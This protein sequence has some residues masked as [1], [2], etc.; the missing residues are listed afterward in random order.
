MVS[1]Y[2]FV[3]AALAAG[4]V[5]LWAA[6]VV[7][8]RSARRRL[9]VKRCVLSAAALIVS[10]VGYGFWEPCWPEVERVTVRS[11]KLAADEPIRLVQLSDLHSEAEPRLEDSLPGIVAGLRPDLIVFT[12]DAINTTRGL[13]HFRRVMARLAD[14]AP[15]FAVRGNWDV[16]WFPRTNLYGGT[17]VRE[18]ASEAVPFRIRRQELWL[19]GVPVDS[20]PAIPG[21]LAQ[22][23]PHRFAVLLHHFPAAVVWAKGADLHLAGD[24]HGGQLRLPWIGALLRISRDGIWK[25]E[26]LQR[27]GQTLLYVNRGIGMEGRLLPVRFLCRPE[28]TLF[29][30]SAGS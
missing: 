10:S 24:T 17:G 30:I 4:L 28:I 16:W 9:W 6:V 27:E 8:G 22:V 25:P 21:L 14:I 19:V 7:L 20:E 5:L 26:G 11:P 2:R 12:G 1:I 29:E 15:T 13:G 18:L 23:P 3:L